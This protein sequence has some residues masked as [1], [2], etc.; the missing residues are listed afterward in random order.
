MSEWWLLSQAIAVLPAAL[1]W[2]AFWRTPACECRCESKEPLVLLGILEKQLARCGPAQ[3]GPTPVVES[4]W[5]SLWATLCVG[6]LLGAFLV[7]VVWPRL[8]SQVP[9]AFVGKGGAT[10]VAKPSS[11]RALQA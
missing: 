4:S 6:I 3:L 5:S 2:L 8:W 9:S 1:P 11:R 7:G 10:S